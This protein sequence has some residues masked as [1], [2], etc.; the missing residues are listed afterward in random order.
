MS[1]FPQR[2]IIAVLSVAQVIGGIGVGATMAVGSLVIR[3]LTGS[4]AFAGMSVVAMTLGSAVCAIPLARIAVR[5]GRRP[6][7]ASGWGV[8]SL[9]GAVCVAGTAGGSTVAVLA[10]LAMLG[11]ASAT[12]LQSRFA[13]VD[14]SE[15]HRV[16]RTLSIVVWSTTVGA[17]A[18]PNLTGPGAAIARAVGV[19]DLA[20]PILIATC[21]FAAAMLVTA[22]A[23]RPDPLGPR[24]TGHHGAVSMRAALGHLRG[25]AAVAVAALSV[26]LAVMAGVMSLTPVHMADH[27]M[28]LQ[29][30]GLTI[31]IHI[32]GMFAFAPVF[33][34][35]SDSLGAVR[36][37]LF[38]Q[39]LLVAAV[40][41]AGT[42]GHSETRITI[43]LA[44]LGVGWSASTIAGSALLAASLEPGVRASVQGVADSIMQAS[45]AAGGILAGVV[46]AVGDWW[47]LNLITGVLVVAAMVVVALRPARATAP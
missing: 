41:V 17:V 18:G 1:D 4:P 25:P 24:G 34:W 2:R 16:A 26:S 46:V 44:L 14:R 31:S 20:G 10:G 45:G 37:I 9:G 21:C 42:A 30:I 35:L 19:P 5:R 6:A 3:E 33:G 23:L 47:I 7:L 12:G 43:G 36:T 39:A 22:S 32:A 8:A 29:V 28:S 11:S 27:G 15:P 13:A 38:G 40:T